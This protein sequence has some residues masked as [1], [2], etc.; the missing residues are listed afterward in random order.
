[1]SAGHVLVSV[2]AVFLMPISIEDQKEVTFLDTFV[3][4][5]TDFPQG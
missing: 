1:M 3:E 2:V 4:K 5:T